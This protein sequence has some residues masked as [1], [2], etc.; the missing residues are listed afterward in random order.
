MFERF[1][2]DTKSNLWNTAALDEPAQPA[3]ELDLEMRMAVNLSVPSVLVGIYTNVY[4]TG[5]QD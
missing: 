1:S 3:L 4:T 5:H 2:K